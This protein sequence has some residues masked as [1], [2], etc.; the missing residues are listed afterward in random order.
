MIVMHDTK[1]FET[2]RQASHLLSSMG[3]IKGGT[4]SPDKKFRRTCLYSAPLQ[5][6]SQDR[7]E[8]MDQSLS[9]QS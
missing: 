6:R 1:C 7:V 2:T 3:Q 8:L 4:T 9:I 5:P